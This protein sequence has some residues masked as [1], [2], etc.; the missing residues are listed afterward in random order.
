MAWVGRRWRGENAP[1]DNALEGEK[2]SKSE[3]AAG[4]MGSL[5]GHVKIHQLPLCAR[6]EILWPLSARTPHVEDPRILDASAY[7]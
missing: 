2:G 3:R 6:S 1:L 5:V 4:G 7:V